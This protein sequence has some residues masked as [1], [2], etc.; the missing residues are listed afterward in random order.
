MSAATVIFYAAAGVFLLK[1]LWNVVFPFALYFR[2]SWVLAPGQQGTSLATVLELIG[3]AVCVAISVVAD[4]PVEP[5]WL[6]L[7]GLGAVVTSYV[8]LVAFEYLVFR[9]RRTRATGRR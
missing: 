2:P 6:L 8:P 5:L 4:V 1:L 9:P 3:L 7:I